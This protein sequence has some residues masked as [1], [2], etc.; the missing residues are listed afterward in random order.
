ML[1][2]IL[3]EMASFESRLDRSEEDNFSNCKDHKVG[4]HVEGSKNNK[5][6]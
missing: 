6:E 3:P 5:K 4:G 2:K 1:K